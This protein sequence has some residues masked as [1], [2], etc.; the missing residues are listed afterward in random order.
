M[1]NFVLKEIS[2]K[3]RL[4]ERNKEKQEIMELKSQ[5]LEEKRQAV[6]ESR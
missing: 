2:V 4:K 3:R 5:N 1:R 6:Y